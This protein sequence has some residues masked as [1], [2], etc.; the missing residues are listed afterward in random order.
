LSNLFISLSDS[1]N[2]VVSLSLPISSCIVHLFSMFSNCLFEFTLKIV[3]SLLRLV[4]LSAE[5]LIGFLHLFQIFKSELLFLN[6]SISLIDCIS[7]LMDSVFSIPD[8]LALIIN[9]L[10]KP[11][12][13]STELI[14][15]L[16]VLLSFDRRCFW[17]LFKKMLEMGSCWVVLSNE[18]SASYL[19]LMHV[20]HC[21]DLGRERDDN[22][23]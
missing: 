16:F 20:V 14:L 6:S 12:V 21:V 7:S 10:S 1:I 9:S 8:C 13:L 23:F 4:N 2:I 18:L 19:F 15:I 17:R 5:L 11:V 3:S 22:T